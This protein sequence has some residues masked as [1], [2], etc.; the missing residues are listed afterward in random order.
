MFAAGAAGF[1]H[2]TDLFTGVLG[3]KIVKKIPSVEKKDA[4]AYLLQHNSFVRSENMK[5]RGQ[6]DFSIWPLI[7][8]SSEYFTQ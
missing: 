3:I 4:E 1:H 8:Y 5:I 6:D 2:G 7:I